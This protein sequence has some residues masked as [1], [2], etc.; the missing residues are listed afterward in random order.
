[1]RLKSMNLKANIEEE[2]IKFTQELVRRNSP[3][4]QE[5]AVAQLIVDKM[6]SMDF[7]EVFVDDYGSVTGVRAGLKPG[8]RVLFDAHMDVVPV[9]N[10]ESWSC[11]PFGGEQRDGKIW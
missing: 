10:P 4:G 1:M 2:I 8:A 7:D 6:S 3:S 11:D 5:G 9:N